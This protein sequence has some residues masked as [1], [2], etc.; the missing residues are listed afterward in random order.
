MTVK[1]PTPS[2]GMMRPKVATYQIVSRSRS[3]T[4]R[5]RSGRAVVAS[6][7]K[8]ISGAAYR[9]DQLDGILVVDFPAQ[10]PHQHLEHIGE[11]VVV[12]VP[13]V[14]G[15]GGAI[16]HLAVMQNE[17][18][19]QGEFLRRQL[20]LPPGAP[21]S[22]CFQVDLEVGYAQGL[23]QRCAAPAG[24]GAHARE[25]LSEGERL[26]QVV[27]GADIEAGNTVVDGVPRGEHQDR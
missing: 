6:V 17:K 5:L 14:G 2:R 24:K 25:Q 27:V 10:T 15:D 26:G 12:F 4:S 7:A 9:L 1:R 16:D 21:H 3:L 23:G 18:L 8:A 13:D 20:D 11:R 22:L 19:E